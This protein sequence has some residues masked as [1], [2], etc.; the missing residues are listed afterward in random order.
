MVLKMT[1]CKRLRELLSLAILASCALQAQTKPDINRYTVGNLPTSRLNAPGI[2]GLC[3]Q[4]DGSGGVT[5]ATCATG[6]GGSGTVTLFSAGNLPPLFTSSVSS[7]SSTPALTFTLSNAAAHRFFGNNTGGS[8]APG[9]VAIG[10][11]DLPGVFA[12]TFA[13]VAHKWLNSYDSTTGLFTQTQPDYSDLT[14]TP[15]LAANTTATAHQFLTAYNSGTGAFTKAQPDYSDLTGTPTLA[16]SLSKVAH[17]W[18][19]SF[20]ASTGIFTQSQPDYSDLTGTPTLAANTTATAHQFFTAYNSA[21][22]AFTKAQPSTTDLSDFPSQTGNAG[23]FLTT[24][25][26]AL[27][28]GTPAG[29]GGGVTSIFGRT[30]IVTATTGDYSASQVTNAF[31][32]TAAD[33]L[34]NVTAPATPAAG[35]TAVY[36]DSTNKVLSSKNDAGTVSNTV[37]PDTG[38]KQLPYRHQRCRSRQQ[39]AAQLRQS[40]W[41]RNLRTR[42]CAHWRRYELSRILRHHAGHGSHRKRRHRTDGRKRCAQRFTPNPDSQFHINH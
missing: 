29:G 7:A 39:S 11:A 21:T 1:I 6:G 23:L 18:L 17:K 42:A 9:F 30:G 8:G 24:N 37:V 14:G 4:T 36:V 12:Q 40:L 35:K 3:L 33:T 19:D 28:W 15:T 20:N 25:G 13:N 10:A 26:T 27:S 16:A 22:G 34:S 2:A 31:D 5:L 38:S 41:R 32:V